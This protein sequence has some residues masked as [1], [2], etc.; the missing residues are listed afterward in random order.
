[1]GDVSL[2]LIVQIYL[3]DTSL[4]YTENVTVLPI[5]QT[6]IESRLTLLMPKLFI[7]FSRIAHMYYWTMPT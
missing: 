1:M 7:D 6:K 3:K 4:A 5:N 2:A